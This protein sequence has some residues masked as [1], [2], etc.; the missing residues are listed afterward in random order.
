MIRWALLLLCWPLAAQ[1]NLD[2]LSRADFVQN[3][4]T[5]KEFTIA[6]AETMPEEFYGYKVN[7]EEMSFAG[8]MV[9]IAGTNRFRFAQ[10]SEDKSPAPAAPE[11]TKVAIIDSMRESFDYCIGKLGNITEE[12]FKK[13]FQVGWYQRPAA[14]GSQI[15]LG[16]Y[17]HTAHHRAQA[18]VYMRAN[19]IKPPDYRP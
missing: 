11:L 19:N 12:Q 6:V 14:S 17:V 16:M 9:H 2:M 3:W 15:L 1:Q 13:Q 4:K 10:I 8:L 18:E 5:S 7:A